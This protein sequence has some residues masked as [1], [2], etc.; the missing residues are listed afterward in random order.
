MRIA[1]WV[2][3]ITELSTNNDG[4]GV[5]SLRIGDKVQLKTWNNAV[6][7]TFDRTLLIPGSPLY[8]KAITLRIGQ[9]VSIS[10]TFVQDEKDCVRESSQLCM[11]QC[12][13]PISSS[14]LTI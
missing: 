11:V 6:S 1:G 10:G 2:G 14:D 13:N 9:R 5:I 8:Q 12:R 4:R 7:D 3:T